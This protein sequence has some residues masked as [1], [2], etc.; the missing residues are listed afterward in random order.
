M[1]T[2]DAIMTPSDDGCWVLKSEVVKELRHSK[3]KRCLAMARWCEMS[4]RENDT[5]MCLPEKQKFTKHEEYLY[6]IGYY[7][8]WHRRWLELATKF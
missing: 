7:H 2:Y 6:F 8:K 5:R 1:Q 4:A 3:R